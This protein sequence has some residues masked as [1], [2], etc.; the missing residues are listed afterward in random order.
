MCGSATRENISILIRY[1]AND[2]TK[3]NDFHTTNT[4]IYTFEYDIA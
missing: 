1:G 4:H 3:Q 2:S